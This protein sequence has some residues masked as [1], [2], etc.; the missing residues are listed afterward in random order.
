MFSKIKVWWIL[1]RRNRV[2]VK[3]GTMVKING[4][5][6]VITS[7]EWSRDLSGSSIRLS[8]ENPAIYMQRS[9]IKKGDLR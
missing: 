7:I 2:A 5:Y 1:R 9:W 8:G 6:F 3:I 4:Y